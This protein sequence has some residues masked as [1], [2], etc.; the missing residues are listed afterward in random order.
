[1]PLSHANSLLRLFCH[2]IS[3]CSSKQIVLTVHLPAPPAL[4]VLYDH[5]PTHHSLP[6][7]L[8]PHPGIHFPALPF[9]HGP[10]LRNIVLDCL[11]D[12]IILGL[13]L[14]NHISHLHSWVLTEARQVKHRT[15]GD[16]T[17]EAHLELRPGLS[18]APC[19]YQKNTAGLSSI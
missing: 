15:R 5:L 12:A 1:M 3:P 19:H 17:M 18:S 14:H 9:H 4:S 11:A 8:S 10:T 13:Y 6:Q 16:R 2:F 7:R